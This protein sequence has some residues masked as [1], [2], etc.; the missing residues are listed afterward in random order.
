[1]SVS[2]D[3]KGGHRLSQKSST[4]VVCNSESAPCGTFGKVCRHAD[5]FDCH[6][7]GDTAGVWRVDAKDSAKCPQNTDPAPWERAR[8]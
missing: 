2:G 7:V 8:G 1:M 5:V 3:S 6:A 4:Q